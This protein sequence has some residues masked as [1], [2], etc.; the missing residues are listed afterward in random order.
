M[1]SL[2]AVVQTHAIVVTPEVVVVVV[3]AER[4][5]H[6]V[7]LLEGR[8]QASVDSLATDMLVATTIER[9]GFKHIEVFVESNVEECEAGQ[10]LAILINLF[11]GLLLEPIDSFTFDAAPAGDTL[12]V[13]AHGVE[14]PQVEQLVLASLIVHGVHIIARADRVGSSFLG[15]TELVGHVELGDVG[16]RQVSLRV[17][18][19]LDIHV[20]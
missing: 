9:L 16:T 14:G 7:E 8:E 18:I 4:G 15:Q 6:V 11:L 20:R 17:V 2:A 10:R 13:V 12:A 3:T 1:P 19:T 5:V